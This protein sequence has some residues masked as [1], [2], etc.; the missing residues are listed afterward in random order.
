MQIDSNSCS[1]TNPFYLFEYK[2]LS[3][4]YH[5]ALGEFISISS[6]AKDV[7]LRI[8]DGSEKIDDI[9]DVSLRE[10]LMRLKS[11]GFFEP[12]KISLPKEKE[13][14]RL[15]EKRY[16]AP[17]TKLE[18][19]L[20]EV[21][22]LACRYCY[23]GTCRDKVQ[24]QG[25][26]SET[27]ARQAI[28]W[29]F[30]VS[31][32]SKEISITF[33]GGE[34]LMNKKVFLFAVNYS[35]RLA[36]LHG[37][38]M[39]YSMTTNGT[40]L[41]DEIISVIK[42]YNFGL[43][44]SLDGPKLLHD[45]QCPMRGGEGSYDLAVSG[46]KKLMA[47]RKRVTVRC[48][49]AHPAP[50]MMELIRF[51]DDFGF[52]RIVLGRVCNP[53]YKSCCDF[54]DSDFREHERQMTDEVIPWILKELRE[55]R[56][57]KYH[58]FAKALEQQKAADSFQPISPFKCGACRGT[59]TVG[60]DGTLYPCHRFV[61]MDKWIIGS[62]SNGPDYEKCKQFWRDYGRCVRETCSDCWAYPLCKGPCPWEVAQDDGTFRINRQ[63]CEETKAWIKQGAWF[64]SLVNS[65]KLLEE[66]RS[67]EV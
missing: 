8:C 12:H 7:L 66:R 34:P 3:F 21:C 4:A 26:M 15:L 1:L 57:P 11:A 31:G 27:I 39:F 23:C 54:T 20:S 24:N 55:G 65:N 10:E 52:S 63:T 59:T 64:C 41:D 46:I 38:K 40:L 14:E 60:A 50:N 62:I 67:D 25:V 56:I 6:V 47:R 29:L 32:Q 36:K 28:N 9:E 22:N 35:Q 61:G 53:V 43:M 13:V 30:A 5:Y 19:A 48:T 33:F 49:M 37:K 42:R 2:G 51:F 45:S 17:W 18:L 58:P 16:D 44:V